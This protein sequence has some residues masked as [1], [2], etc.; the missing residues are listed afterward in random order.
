MTTEPDIDSTAAKLRHLLTSRLVGD[1]WLHSPQW[2]AAVEAVP[3]HEFVRRFYRES[4]SPGLTTWTPVTAELVGV[5]EWLRQAY[6]DDT[7][8]TQFD[9]REIDW[10]DPQPISNAHPTS[11]ST[12]PA[13]VVRM[14]E[15]LQVQDGMTVLE[16]GTGTGYSTALMCHRLG[17]ERVSSIETD[18]DVADRARDALDRC[19]YAPRLIVRDGLAGDSEGAPYD[20]TIAT[21]GVR[22]VPRPWVQQTRPGGLI[23]AT[24]R[25]WMR[26]LGLVRLTVDRTGRAEGRFI[27]DDPS[28]MIARQQEAPLNLGMIPAPDDG[29]TRSTPHGPGLLGMPDSGFVAQLAMPG[30]RFFSMPTHDGTPGT[31]VIDATNGSFAVL[32]PKGDGEWTVRQGGLITLWDEFEQ[33]LAVWHTAGSPPPT[34]FG[35]TVTPQR[36]CVWLGS[37]GG[38]NWRLPTATQAPADTA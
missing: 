11:S 36:Q 7:L 32:T 21:C 33:S 31:Y 1:G 14:L 2:R 28:F 27:A 19:G 12:L 25:G 9:G 35:V 24:L 23:L 18:P 30:A 38:P 16:I 37:P 26:S 5:E 22:H 15:E 6:T 34:A 20:R 10:S 8:I 17:A 13:L 29:T 4:D 3:R